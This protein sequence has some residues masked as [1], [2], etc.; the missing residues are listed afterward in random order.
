MQGRWVARPL[1]LDW[2]WLLE[3]NAF[4]LVPEKLKPQKWLFQPCKA[5]DMESIQIPSMF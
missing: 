3:I 1:T 2:E 5:L 4:Y